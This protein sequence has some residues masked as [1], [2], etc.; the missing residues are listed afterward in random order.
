MPYFPWKCSD[1]GKGG[2]IRHHKGATRDQIIKLA[3]ASH[4]VKSPEC[5]AKETQ[6]QTALLQANDIKPRDRHIL[7]SARI[8]RRLMA[9]ALRQMR[10]TVA[11]PPERSGPAWDAWLAQV[12]HQ[13]Q[14][15]RKTFMESR[16]LR[17]GYAF[18]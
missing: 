14:T 11:A 6:R 4:A 12:G 2:A 10:G 1:C 7:V 5:H 8:K 17:N 9:D 13:R 15:T 16:K 18:T 3:G